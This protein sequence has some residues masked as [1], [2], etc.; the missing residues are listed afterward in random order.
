M[1]RLTGGCFCAAAPAKRINNESRA[2]AGA[3]EEKL[4]QN[5]SDWS[6]Y[7]PKLTQIMNSYVQIPQHWPKYEFV[8]P[9][10]Y[11]YFSKVPKTLGVLSGAQ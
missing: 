8:C 2:P 5:C 6:K 1:L 11:V 7:A 10:S 4:G 3:S 9:N